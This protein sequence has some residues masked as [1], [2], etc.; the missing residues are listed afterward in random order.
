M[1]SILTLYSKVTEK[2][3]LPQTIYCDNEPRITLMALLNE[4]YKAV[5]INNDN[6]KLKEYIRNLSDIVF[7]TPT[8]S[9]NEYGISKADDI[10]SIIK[11]NT[12]FKNIA[13]STECKSLYG[14]FID[15][16]LSIIDDSSIQFIYKSM[17]KPKAT[18]HSDDS[19]FITDPAFD[20]FMDNSD[21]NCLLNEYINGNEFPISSYHYNDT[22]LNDRILEELETYYE[23]ILKPLG[24]Y[25]DILRGRIKRI[26]VLVHSV[27]NGRVDEDSLHKQLRR[28]IDIIKE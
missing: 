24:D 28:E 11:Y 3:I 10:E 15:D 26:S 18:I 4:G 21:I 13:E 23:S 22:E 8:C 14:K 27:H 16:M 5:I 25:L 17:A 1:N 6:V 9:L 7:I 2:T 19:G 12:K 20:I